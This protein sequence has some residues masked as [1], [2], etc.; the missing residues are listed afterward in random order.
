MVR[1]CTNG[2]IYIWVFSV[3]DELLL[4]APR[5]VRDAVA[6]K[7]TLLWC[8]S[9]FLALF[10]GVL[11]L[12][13]ELLYLQLWPAEGAFGQGGVDGMPP[14]HAGAS[15]G[16]VPGRE[17]GAGG[18]RREGG[19]DEGRERRRGARREGEG[20]GGEGGSLNY[21][22]GCGL[23]LRLGF[24]P[25]TTLKAPKVPRRREEERLPLLLSASPPLLAPYIHPRNQLRFA[26]RG[27][28][29]P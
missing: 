29:T 28:H 27:K 5:S 3:R 26:R 18:V 24:L 4:H 17:E 2:R 1:R 16:F 9:F 7:G 6:A 22:P 12:F 11:R 19:R 10:V 20:V 21:L 25:S 13:A 23:I 8:F 14:S 15:S